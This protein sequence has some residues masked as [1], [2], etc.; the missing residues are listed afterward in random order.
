MRAAGEEYLKDYKNFHSIDGSAEATTLDDESIDMITV[1]A[2]FHWFDMKKTK[3]EFNRILKRGAWV[4]LV[5]EIRCID[6]SS[7]MRDYE[8]LL[9]KYSKDYKESNARKL[10]DTE[11]AKFY[12]PNEMHIKTFKNLQRFDWEG[13]KGRLLSISYSLRSGDARYEEMLVELKQIFD[14]YQKSGKK[15]DYLYD[16][17]VNYGHIHD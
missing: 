10:D 17:K 6:R 15:I 16:T 4:I 13:L 5:W 2:A 3:I 11:F 7:L 8:A 14:K 1:G 9:L 12:S